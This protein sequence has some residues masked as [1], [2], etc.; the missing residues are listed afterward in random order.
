[1][2]GHPFCPSI[3]ERCVA[4]SSSFCSLLSLQRRC[5]SIDERCVARSSS[6]CSLLSLQRR[7]CSS[8]FERGAVCDVCSLGNA[9]VDRD[10]SDSGNNRLCA[11]CTMQQL[12]PRRPLPCARQC[13]CTTPPSLQ[14]RCHLQKGSTSPCQPPALALCQRLTGRLDVRRP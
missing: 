4:R 9:F 1:M 8:G 12:F 11:L 14:C 2:H 5:C 6:F 3:D 10:Y 7:C 13:R